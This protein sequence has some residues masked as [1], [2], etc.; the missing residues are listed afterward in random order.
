MYFF[1]ETNTAINKYKHIEVVVSTDS[2]Y[3]TNPQNTGGSY[4]IKMQ[5]GLD[6]AEYILNFLSDQKIPFN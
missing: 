2:E 1:Q 3:L 5:N 4:F 6:E